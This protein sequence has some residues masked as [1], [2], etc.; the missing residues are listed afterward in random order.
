MSIQGKKKTPKQFT[1]TDSCRYVEG[2]VDSM[3]TVRYKITTEVL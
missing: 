3:S 1:T 2:K